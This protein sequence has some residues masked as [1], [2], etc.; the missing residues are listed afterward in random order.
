MPSRGGHLERQEKI[1]IA[2]DGERREEMPIASGRC[3]PGHSRRRRCAGMKEVEDEGPAAST[4]DTTAQEA[5]REGDTPCPLVTLRRARCGG[6]HRL[7]SAEAHGSNA[8][9]HGLA[10]PGR[11]RQPCSRLRKRVADSGPRGPSVGQSCCRLTSRGELGVPPVSGPS[12][13]PAL[14]PPWRRRRG[15]R[16]GDLGDGCAG[17]YIVGHW[18]RVTSRRPALARS[19]LPLLE[20]QGARAERRHVEVVPS[21]ARASI[22]RAAAWTR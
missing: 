8:P 1:R 14:R 18:A 22:R 5:E 21:A 13:S 3:R 17:H 7:R 16:R 4:P 6:G 15:R 19:R 20:R 11:S 10:Q 2:Q 9:V 12:S